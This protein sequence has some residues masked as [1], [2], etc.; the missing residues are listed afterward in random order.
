M[1]TLLLFF[2]TL[3]CSMRFDNLL[4]LCFPSNTTYPASCINSPE[5]VHDFRHAKRP[6][7]GAHYKYTFFLLSRAYPASETSSNSI[8]L[9]WNIPCFYPKKIIPLPLKWH[10]ILYFPF[11]KT[12]HILHW[13]A[14]S[15]IY[16][17]EC[18]NTYTL[19]FSSFYSFWSPNYV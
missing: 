5:G 8:Y 4:L 9:P 18:P 13:I 19:L 16:F 7:T 11:L 6:G 2:A 3:Q 10:S 14:F 12:S 17:L 1:L 15:C